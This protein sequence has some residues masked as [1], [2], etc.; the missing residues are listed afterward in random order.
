MA[1]LANDAFVT[2]GT[3]SVAFNC[4]FDGPT[5]EETVESD[6]RRFAALAALPQVVIA[7]IE[8]SAFAGDL[9]FVCAADI[10]LASAEARFAAPEARRGLVAAQI[11]PWIARRTGRSHAARMVLQGHVLD[12]AEA[13]RTG[14]VHEILPDAAA[15]EAR[16]A[17]TVADILQGAPGALAET[18]ALLAALGDAV[19]PGYAEAGAQAFARCG[20]SG[21]AEEGIAAFKAKRLPAWVRPTEGSV[22]AAQ[23][24]CRRKQGRAVTPRTAG[25]RRATHL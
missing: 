17:A 5:P 22:M 23:V 13:A 14:L 25:M 16:V 21:E 15:L 1:A 12:A 6:A 19:P 2:V 24:R 18:K 10:A 9:G 4:P 11:L 20:A 3:I 8:G 7:S